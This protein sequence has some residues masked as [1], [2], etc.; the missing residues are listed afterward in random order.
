MNYWKHKA[1]INLDRGYIAH[2]QYYGINDEI[3]IYENMLN[4]YDEECMI[5]QM[6]DGF[7]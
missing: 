7:D 2:R 5:K 4:E 3:S 6:H 1:I